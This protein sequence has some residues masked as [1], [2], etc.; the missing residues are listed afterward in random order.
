MNR[1]RPAPVFSPP[2][3]AMTT[4]PGK[5]GGMADCKSTTTAAARQPGDDAM[6]YGLVGVTS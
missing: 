1:N 4:N 2:M 6:G 3:Q 5:E